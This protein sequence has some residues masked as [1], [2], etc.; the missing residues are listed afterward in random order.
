[1]SLSV[2]SVGIFVKIESI[3]SVKVYPAFLQFILKIGS[4]SDCFFVKDRSIYNSILRQFHRNFKKNIEIFTDDLRE[5]HYFVTFF[6]YNKCV[7]II[8]Q[9]TKKGILYERI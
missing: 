2:S 3:S 9:I 6:R 5:L 4:I 7:D 1:M 8:F